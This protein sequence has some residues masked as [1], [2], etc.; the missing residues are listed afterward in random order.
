MKALTLT[1]LLLLAPVAHAQEADKP[2]VTCEENARDIAAV[3]SRIADLQAKYNA[4]TDDREQLVI[5]VEGAYMQK[6][7]EFLTTWRTKHCSDI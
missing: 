1:A 7:G 2:V 6:L 4:A 5:G 3:K